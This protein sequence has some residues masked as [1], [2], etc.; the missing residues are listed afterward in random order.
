MMASKGLSRRRFLGRAGLALST[1]FFLTSDA[2]GAPE[3]DPASERIGLGLIGFHNMGRGHLNKTLGMRQFEVCGCC[4]VDRKILAG[5]LSTVERRA[6]KR[7][8]GWGDYRRMLDAKD[9]DAVVIAAPDHW[10]ALMSIHACQAGK[11]VYCEKPLSLTVR[12][13]RLMVEAVRRYGR[14]FQTGS[15]HRSKDHTRLACELVRNGR[16]GKVHTIRTG[17]A[18]VNWPPPPVSDSAPPPELDYDMWLGPAPYRAYNT[19]RVHYN[20]RFFWDYSGGQ[21]TNFGHHSNDLA[22]WGN[23]TELTGPISAEGKAEYEPHGWYEVPRR[24]EAILEYANGARLICRTGGPGGALFEGS[25]G[26]ILCG[27]GG[28]EA[29][30]RHV[31]AEPLGP[32]DLRLYRSTDHHA[33]WAECVKARKKPIC[34]VEIGH[35]SVTVCLL[36]NTAILVGRKIHWDPDKEEIIG[37]EDAARMLDKPYRAPWHL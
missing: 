37:D 34:D 3:K 7:V 12:E 19:K 5:A 20:F 10:H 22:Q 4:D 16:I 30:P 25:E 15:Q 32:G 23:G 14:V 2:L 21:M 31:A 6:K 28:L 27:Y 18:G 36:A 8:P 11:D 29:H 13:G 26:R 24:S 33:N 1:P 17:L 9:I 35:R